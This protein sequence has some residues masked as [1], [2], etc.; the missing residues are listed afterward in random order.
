MDIQ[1]LPR[2]WH[3]PGEVADLF[4]ARDS[5]QDGDTLLLAPGTWAGGVDFGPWNVAVVGDGAPE[6]VIIQAPPG[7]DHVLHFAGSPVEGSCWIEN[8]TLQGGNGGV[9]ADSTT[10]YARHCLL[11]EGGLW[12]WPAFHDD[13]DLGGLLDARHCVTRGIFL[14]IGGIV[15]Y[16][17]E[18]RNTV[19]V[20]PL[21]EIPDVERQDRTTPVVWVSRC[22]F[23]N[24][25]KTVMGGESAY[26]TCASLSV[27]GEGIVQQ[28]VFADNHVQA[29]SESTSY[30]GCAGLCTWGAVDV[31]ECL[32]AEN[33]SAASEEFSGGEAAS[34]AACVT[35]SFLRNT[36]VGNAALSSNQLN[37]SI[38]HVH[39][40]LT[41]S[42]FADNLGRRLDCQS[43]SC[44]LYWNNRNHQTGVPWTVGNC[45]ENQGGEVWG[46]PLFYDPENRDYRL[47]P[48]SAAWPPNHQDE[49][50]GCGLLGAFGLWQPVEVLGLALQQNPLRA[51]LQLRCEATGQLL[52][53]YGAAD[54]GGPFSE[55]TSLPAADTLL[56]VDIPLGSYLPARRF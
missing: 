44:N 9:R 27:N 18:Q 53:I 23:E 39:G 12:S 8:L 10:L 48:G 13:N 4:A 6:Q 25:H 24:N 17:C 1:R 38:V 37:N 15:L 2:T 50:P 47:L 33:V 16:E 21:R 56:T 5:L 40:E 26:A 41:E 49:A 45:G 19:V 11:P 20:W 22:R 42:L 32:F 31:V 52:H 28:C 14:G 3:L 30:A 54:A 43:S 55:L 51:R 7:E 36:V 34:P 35:G 46:D 29:I